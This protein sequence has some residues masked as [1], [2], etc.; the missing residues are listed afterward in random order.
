VTKQ[1]LRLFGSKKKRAAVD[2][3]TYA[4]LAEGEASLREALGVGAA[5]IAELRE[6]ARVLYHSEKWARC[7]Q[8]MFAIDALGA[9]EPF[10]A[11]ILSR[12][13]DELGD[14]ESAEDVAV[15]AQGMLKRLDG[16]LGEDDSAP[17]EDED[18]TEH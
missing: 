11:V 13:F 6:Q 9:I 2:E 4:A 15:L 8:L 18:P 5:T 10:D 1:Q 16:L 12:C 14:P 3:K 17:D 7:I